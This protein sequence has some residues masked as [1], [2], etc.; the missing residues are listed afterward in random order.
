MPDALIFHKSPLQLPHNGPFSHFLSM[1]PPPPG[2]WL[3]IGLLPL[4]I[5]GD[6][7]RHMLGRILAWWHPC[8]AFWEL[9]LS[10]THWIRHLDLAGSDF[11]RMIFQTHASLQ[12]VHDPYYCMVAV[13]LWHSSFI[14]SLSTKS[15]ACL[16]PLGMVS[17]S[18][19]DQFFHRTLKT[20]RF[21][22]ASAG[23]IF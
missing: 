21:S 15:D 22:F 16:S 13:F 9:K 17:C 19:T 23:D 6:Y 14:V 7:N 2:I 10:D 18:C 20:P 1:S 12:L 4:L 8:N 5:L 3:V 11:Q